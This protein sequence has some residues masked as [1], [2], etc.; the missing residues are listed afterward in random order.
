MGKG[1][2]KAGGRWRVRYL[3]HLGGARVGE[4]GRP[5]CESAVPRERDTE[6]ASDDARHHHRGCLQEPLT[7]PDVQGNYIQQWTFWMIDNHQ[8]RHERG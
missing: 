5:A 1:L 8:L 6:S 2:E 7:V 4:V 3:G